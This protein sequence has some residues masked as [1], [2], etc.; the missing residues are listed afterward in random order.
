MKGRS[1]ESGR[2]TDA[3]GG[4]WRSGEKGRSR[5]SLAWG[6]GGDLVCSRRRSLGQCQRPGAGTGNH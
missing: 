1:R 5:R 6:K 3:A 4:P 2:L